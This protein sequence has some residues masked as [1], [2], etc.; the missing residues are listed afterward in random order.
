[1]AD[2]S[3]CAHEMGITPDE[4]LE[5]F[6]PMYEKGLEKLAP[7]VTQVREFDESS[8]QI[9]IINNS[10]NPLSEGNRKWQGV[11]HSAT[12]ADDTAPRIINSTCV[13]PAGFSETTLVG[14]AQVADFLEMEQM[15]GTYS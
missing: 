7:F 14:P 1:M 9:L 10:S 4:F 12:V 15:S 13:A 6:N 3:R 11:L 2:Y 5:E 8:F